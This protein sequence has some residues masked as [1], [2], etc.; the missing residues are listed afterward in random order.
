MVFNGSFLGVNML[1]YGVNTCLADTGAGGC[2]AY[3]SVGTLHLGVGGVCSGGLR[4]HRM[5]LDCWN[6]AKSLSNI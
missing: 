2:V 3:A 4:I 1:F 5:F 6:T